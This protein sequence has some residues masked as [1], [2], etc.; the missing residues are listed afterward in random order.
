MVPVRQAALEGEAP[1]L[2]P[3]QLFQTYI[4]IE[5]GDDLVLFDQHALHEKILFERI[6]E[7]M[8]AG[9]MPR[10]R[11]LFPEVVTLPLELVPLLEETAR[12]LSAL[13]FEA[14]P[15]GPR[16]LAVHAVPAVLESLPAGPIV[17]EAARW[18]REGSPGGTVSP[19]TP[20]S[21]APAGPDPLGAE[22]RRLAQLIACKRAVKAGMPLEAAEVQALFA[23]ALEAADPRF[24]P[25]GRPTSA[26]ITRSEL[27]RRFQRK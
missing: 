13:G 16:E 1:A 22:A 6:L 20:G 26:V 19:G 18:I 15:F 10:Q 11:L 24:C 17:L 9:P 23:G 4:A 14:E 7:Q 27:E 12:R 3:V 5:S 2:R 25:H 8:R 21:A